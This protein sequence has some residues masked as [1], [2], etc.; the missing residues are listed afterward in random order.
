MEEDVCVGRVLE[1]LGGRG[2]GRTTTTSQELLAQQHLILLLLLLLLVLLLLKLVGFVAG[3][4]TTHG[5]VVQLLL[6]R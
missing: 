3:T 6:L 4:A 5:E 1:G 2:R